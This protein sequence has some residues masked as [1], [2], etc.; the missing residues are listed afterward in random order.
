[1]LRIRSS[2]ACRSISACAT[3]N[4]HLREIVASARRPVL[5]ARIVAR[6]QRNGAL[7]WRGDAVDAGLGGV[8]EA[9]LQAGLGEP[10]TVCGS[11]RGETIRG[12]AGAI[13]GRQ[14]DGVTPRFASTHLN[15]TPQRVRRESA[16]RPTRTMDFAAGAGR[17]L[18]SRLFE[19]AC[20]CSMP[21][22]AFRPHPDR[23]LRRREACRGVDRWRAG[24]Q[25]PEPMMRSAVSVFCSIMASMRSSSVPRT[26]NLWTCTVR[27]C[28]MRW[29]RSVA[30]FLHGGVPPAI[31]M[32]DVRR[33]GE[34]QAHA[35]GLEADDEG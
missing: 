34:I 10:G 27:N 14:Q 12:I 4:H 15:I 25:P 35:A 30:W 18:D 21:D 22:R 26:T 24:E 5:D 17:R 6:G 8:T 33:G 9:M 16:R 31:E 3:E 7:R 13:P 19:R 28:P 23:V 29:A 1:M 20:G 2:V 32:E 11:G